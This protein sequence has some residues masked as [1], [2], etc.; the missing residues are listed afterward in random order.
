M[1]KQVYRII[2]LIAV[3]IASIFYFSRDIKEVVFD[4]D[5]TTTMEET[6]FPVITVRTGEEELNLARGYSTNL[7]ANKI[8]EGV[9]PLGE[10]QSFEVVIRQQ[11]YEIKKLNYEVREYVSNKLIE[12]DS[13]S[14]FEG[15]NDRKIAKIKL[16]TELVLDRDYAV[17]ITLITSE[18]KKMYF[19]QR[20]K[21]CESPYLSEKLEFVLDF[22]NAL[23]NK[24]TAEWIRDRL[25]TS[26]KKDNSTL[27]HI[28]IHS[29]YDLV[30]WGNLNPVFLTEVIPT[31]TE[32]NTNFASIT[33]EYM[34]EA[35]IAG[36][37]E[38]FQVKEFYRVQY[39][40]N[41]NYLLNYE[42]SMEA[43]FD[44]NLASVSMNQLKL[45]ITNQTEVPYLISP[46]HKKL[47]FVRNRELWYYSM[48]N[49]QMTRVFSFRQDKTDYIRDI[50]NQHDIRILNMDAE[51]NI[52][53]LVY[54]YMNR[55]QYEGKVAII[56]YKY[57]MADNR[58]EERV[59]IPVDEPYQTLKERMGTLAYVNALEEFYFHIFDHIYSYNLITRQAKE[60][61]SGIG[62]DQVVFLKD[63]G[64]VAWQ[65]DSDPIKSKEIRI[66]EL[67]TGELQTINTRAGYNILLM[68]NIDSNLVYGFV[69]EQDIATL[70]D[71]KTIIPM[72]MIEIASIEKQI[73]KS[74]HKEGFF[75]TDLIVKDNIIELDRVQKRDTTNG[76][77]Y[78]AAPQD[79]IMNQIKPKNSVI[80]VLPRI[81]EQALTE[82]YLSLPS[83]F[84]MEEVPNLKF[85]VNTV[86]DEDPTLRLPETEQERLLYYAH[87]EGNLQEAYEE[88]SDAIEVVKARSGVV[89]DSFHRIVWEQGVKSTKSV[90]SGYD[91]LSVEKTMDS[92]ESCITLMLKRM[93]KYV[94]R[95]QIDLTSKSAYEILRE[96]S[97]LQPIRITGASLEDV[98][99]YVTKGKP[100]I[101][102]T[103]S[104]SA[105]LIYGYDAF[106]IQVVDPE[107]GRVRKIG[108]QD[109]KNLFEQAGNVYISYLDQ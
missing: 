6:T 48:E 30:T 10:D 21:R 12:S 26:P 14:V 54:G 15:D 68:D 18:S 31:I 62:K 13:V 5:N 86:I 42:R 73:L 71:G 105:V 101:A 8:W 91:N 7:D 85:T 59:Y 4:I 40:R 17:K 104:H 55:G 58:I 44:A 70:M 1:L 97:Q 11:D 52:D 9:T 57:I 27:A 23:K 50:Y 37:K 108:L 20:V 75:V 39:T 16:N 33:L 72:R 34:I 106:N 41:R 24:E 96:Q 90:I 82:Y 64:Y 76:I 74:Y 100:V 43:L 2:I 69:S 83:G 46:D 56:L 99:Y 102:M 67:E 93:G 51:G 19:Y 29:S 98:L 25:E 80:S 53:F 35:D 61:A 95:Q 103:G 92:L 28:D 47:A 78:V 107:Q 81:T 79:Y 3:F 60:L 77:S 94:E 45:G 87:I 65:G 109:S 32:I 38:V 49:N 89:L 84:A 36:A 88:A 63:K 22:H 66:M